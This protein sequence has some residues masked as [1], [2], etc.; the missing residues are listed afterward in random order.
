MTTLQARMRTKL[1]TTDV[2][3][4]P[5][6]LETCSCRGKVALC[7]AIYGAS[8]CAEFL[9]LSDVFAA[10]KQYGIPVSGADAYR[11]AMVRRPRLIE[12]LDAALDVIDA[13]AAY[14]SQVR[15]IRTD[16]IR[17]YRIIG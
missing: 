13:G 2:R 11:L 7:M 16:M 1:G 5:V 12:S 3:L 14:P 6:Q 15:A 17:K 9:L 8:E 10:A 4:R